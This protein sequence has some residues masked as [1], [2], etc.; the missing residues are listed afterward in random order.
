MSVLVATAIVTNIGLFREPLE[1][2][3]ADLFGVAPILG[4]WLAVTSW[5]WSAG[6]GARLCSWAARLAVVLSVSSVAVATARVGGAG[7][8]LKWLQLNQGPLGVLNRLD[9]VAYS[10]RVYPWQDQWPSGTGWRL[11]RYIRNCTR[12]G[13]RLLMTWN[14]PE[15]NFWSGRPFAGGETHF[16]PYRPPSMFADR[17]LARLRQQS[18]PFILV[19]P[20]TYVGDFTRW[21]P[22]IAAHIAERYDKVGHFGTDTRDDVDVYAERDR[23]PTGVDDEFHWPC[24]R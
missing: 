8:A 23:I 20:S 13:D 18:V 12:P 22:A 9:D 4:S 19:E 2:R 14:K 21:Y 16:V 7:D 3:A 5:R 6:A 15:M 17:A 10:A 11:A 24:F 1:A